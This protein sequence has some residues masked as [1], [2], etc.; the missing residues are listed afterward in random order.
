MVVV[1]V[2]RTGGCRTSSLAGRS[3]VGKGG[4]TRGGPIGF[5]QAL[6][7]SFSE[8][9]KARKQKKLKKKKN[10][11]PTSEEPTRL[12]PDPHPPTAPTLPTLSLCLPYFFRLFSEAAAATLQTTNNFP[13]SST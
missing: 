12:P 1:M 7:L 5:G 2:E 13:F 3:K 4:G 10:E 8:Q 9:I 11:E 6:P